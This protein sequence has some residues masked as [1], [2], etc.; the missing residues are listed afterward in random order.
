MH[1]LDLKI[2]DAKHPLLCCI[3]ALSEPYA[4]EYLSTGIVAWAMSEDARAAGII[5]NFKKIEISIVVIY[6]LLF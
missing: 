4:V 5:E 3:S 6:S 1:W 2:A